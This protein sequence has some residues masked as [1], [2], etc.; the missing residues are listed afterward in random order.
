MLGEGLA[1]GALA[2][3]SAHRRRLRYGPFR[4]KLVLGG[5]GF[6][7]FERQRQLL[8]QAR[9]TLRPLPVDLMP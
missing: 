3:K 9:R 1:L 4:R 8:D 2:G 7:L 6:Q 5:V